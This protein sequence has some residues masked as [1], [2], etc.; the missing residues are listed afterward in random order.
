MLRFTAVHATVWGRKR[1]CLGLFLRL[2]AF[3]NI[4]F[5]VVFLFFKVVFLLFAFWVCT[6]EGSFSTCLSLFFHLFQFIFA[7]VS[8]FC[9]DFF[10]REKKRPGLIFWLFWVKRWHVYGWKASETRFGKKSRLL[11]T[12]SSRVWFS[13]FYGSRF[14]VYGC[15]GFSTAEAFV[16]TNRFFPR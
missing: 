8:V 13:R 16:S 7:T 6:F 10:W 15:A 1:D 11:K 3:C 4:M 14:M 12:S 5:E 9:F 2:L